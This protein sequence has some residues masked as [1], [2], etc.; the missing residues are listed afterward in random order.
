MRAVD[1][2]RISYGGTLF[3]LTS[4]DKAQTYSADVYEPAPIGRGGT[5]TKSELSKSN[6]EVRLA[7][8]H[9]LAAALLATWDETP[10]TITVFSKETS[11]TQ[12]I[13]KGR[14]AS[15]QP[16]DV[17][18]K[19]VF[20]SIY[21]SMRRPG[22]RARFQKVCRHPLYSRGCWLDAE[23]YAVAATISAITGP[24]VTVPAAASQSDGWYAGGMIREPGGVL[25]YISKHAGSALTL[26]R[27]SSALIAAFAD[28]GVGTAVTIYPGCDHSY[29]TC[30]TKFGND[31][32]YGGFDY[33]PSKNPMG[34]SSII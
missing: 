22:L 1:L 33:I 29:A 6:F 30:L 26:N 17:S 24:V 32:N 19:M 8:E 31:D 11:G 9:A 3:L 7:L 18:V 15:V 13:W 2:Y 34:G 21:T 16:D 14:L 5:Q 12:V 27:V 20:E 23:D 4:A 25:S 10:T 28:T